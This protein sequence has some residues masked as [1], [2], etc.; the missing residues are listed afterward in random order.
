MSDVFLPDVYWLTRDKLEGELSPRIDVWCIRPEFWGGENGD[1]TWLTP[2][3][4]IDKVEA[5]LCSWSVAEAQRRVGN[6]VPE[7]ER[8]CLRVGNIEELVA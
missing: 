8:E 2:M 4:L 1:G 5:R 3:K 7:S 6:G